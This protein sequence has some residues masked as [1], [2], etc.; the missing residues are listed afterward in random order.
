[1]IFRQGHEGHTFI[2]AIYVNERRSIW[3][4]ERQHEY[5]HNIIDITLV[6]HYKYT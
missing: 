1:M 3:K 5:S 2:I 4:Y 6:Y